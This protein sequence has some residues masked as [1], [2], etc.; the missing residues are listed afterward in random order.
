M[1]AGAYAPAAS[2]FAIG[3]SS[4]KAIQPVIM[5]RILAPYE[6]NEQTGSG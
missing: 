6:G 3:A 5:R 4:D 2:S 1:V